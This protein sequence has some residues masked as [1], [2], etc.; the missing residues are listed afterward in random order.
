M[1]TMELTLFNSVTESFETGTP[2]ILEKYTWIEKISSDRTHLKIIDGYEGSKQ[3]GY[4]PVEMV[5]SDGSL[6][7]NPQHGIWMKLVYEYTELFQMHNPKTSVSVFEARVKSLTKIIQ[8]RN[9]KRG[10]R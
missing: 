2:E 4:I 9:N 7:S 5:L 10:R 1:V 6:L 8:W 3:A